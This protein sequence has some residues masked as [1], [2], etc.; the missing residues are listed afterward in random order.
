MADD[1]SCGLVMCLQGYTEWPVTFLPYGIWGYPGSDDTSDSP[2]RGLIPPPS[3]N[4][5]WAMQGTTELASFGNCPPTSHPEMRL[6]PVTVTATSTPFT[7]WTHMPQYGASPGERKGACNLASLISHMDTSM[8]D[9]T[10]R[11]ALAGSHL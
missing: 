1:L 2:I 3:F 7:A 5:S 11:G 10:Y 8:P 9:Y 4:G 6:W